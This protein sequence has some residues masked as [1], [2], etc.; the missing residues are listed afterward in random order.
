MS[1]YSALCN[2]CSCLFMIILLSM[3]NY[4]AINLEEKKTKAWACEKDFEHQI[5][6]P[7]R[8][9][10]ACS[11][12]QLTKSLSQG[13]FCLLLM[14]IMKIHKLTAPNGRICW[15]ETAVWDHISLFL[16][17]GKVGDGQKSPSS[18]WKGKFLMN[19]ARKAFTAC[20]LV[21][22]EH[23]SPCAQGKV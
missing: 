12:S 18:M 1:I 5:H 13:N 20:V 11:E 3:K 6:S 14:D 4:K 19:S 8:N 16:C 10:S 9:K 17:N 15:L 23:T 2:Y 21:C 22:Q 7:A